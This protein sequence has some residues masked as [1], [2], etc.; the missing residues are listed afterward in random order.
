MKKLSSIQFCT[1][2]YFLILANNLGLTT[3]VLFNYAK[4]DAIISIIIGIILGLIPLT[5]YIKI[6]NIKKELNIFEKIDKIFK[7]GKIINLT[8]AISIMYFTII[9]YNNLINFISSQY[10]SKTPQ[11]IIA[12]S[13]LPAIIYILNKG[14]TVIGRTIFILF[15]ISA[16]FVIITILGLTWQIKI[17][18]LFPIFENG[19]KNIITCSCIYAIYNITPL[20]LLTTIPK[21]EIIDKE[22][23]DKRIIITYIIANIITL[24]MYFLTLTILGKNLT[25]LYQYPEYDVLKKV[26]LIGF[27]ERT[28][29]TISLRW[30]FYVFTVTIMGILFITKYIKHSLKIKNKKTNNKIIFTISTSIIILA[31]YLFQ[32]KSTYNIFIYKKLPIITTIILIIIPLII[33]KKEKNDTSTC[34]VHIK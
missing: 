4:Q 33:I 21:N 13:F 30:T 19:F 9:N 14:T 18:N 34:Q 1:I 26:S 24:T 28:E 10:L 23:L 16:L 17:D 29:S 6:I 5:I 32:N 22:K 8:L 11:I 7:K 3:Y 31:N 25:V 20:F 15:S 2:E 27:I 12:L